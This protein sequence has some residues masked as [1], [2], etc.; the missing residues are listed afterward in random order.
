MNVVAIS[1]VY[2]LEIVE[3][4]NEFVHELE[5]A[6]GKD[7]SS[8]YSLSTLLLE[9]LT[10]GNISSTYVATYVDLSSLFFDRTTHTDILCS[11]YKDILT[12]KNELIPL[13]SA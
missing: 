3:K 13:N 10:K 5:Q 9:F 8:L 12:T 1:G 6:Q 11:C 7:V 2:F 4:L